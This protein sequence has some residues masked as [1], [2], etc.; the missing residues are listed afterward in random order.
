MTTTISI[1][2]AQY[3]QAKAFAEKRNL[4]MDELFAVLIDQMVADEE[5]MKLLDSGFFNPNDYSSDG[6]EARFNQ[7]ERETEEEEGVSHEQMM[8]EL[9]EEFPWL[10]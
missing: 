7:I 2:I 5:E 1:P 10:Q 4:T 9:K 6:I 8:T 3:K